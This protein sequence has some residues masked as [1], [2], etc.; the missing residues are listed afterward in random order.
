MFAVPW[1]GSGQPEQLTKSEFPTTGTSWSPDGKVLAL[2]QLRPDTGL[3]IAIVSEGEEKEKIFLATPFDESQPTFS[4]DGHWLAYT[5][6]ESGREEVY[7]RAFPGPG[8]KWQISTEG[9]SNP[10]WSPTGREIFFRAGD[11]VLAVSIATD[12]DTGIIA[13]DV[14]PL[15]SGDFRKAPLNNQEHLYYDVASDGE[16]FVM[17]RPVPREAAPTTLTVVLNWVDEL[18]TRVPTE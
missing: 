16:R 11:E 17:L 13:G 2:Q 4:P 1:D 9:G 6:N 14:I 5:S 7:A 10:Q 15:F 3:D 18:T 12:E 8:G